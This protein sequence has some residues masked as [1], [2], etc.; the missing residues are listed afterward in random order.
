MNY[1]NSFDSFVIKNTVILE[2]K[3]VAGFLTAFLLSYAST[4][5]PKLPSYI[6]KLFNNVIMKTLAFFLIIY[7]HNRNPTVALISAI[8]FLAI[9]MILNKIQPAK[10]EKMTMLDL[11]TDLLENLNNL[12]Q[13]AMDFVTTQEGKIVLDETTKA[14]QEGVLHP[15]EAEMLIN[16]II[17]AEEQ[18]STPLVA[19]SDEGA[20][21]MSNIA[22]AVS[23]GKIP[24]DEGKRIAAQIVINENI[25][26]TSETPR[27][28]ISIFPDW[29]VNIL[30]MM[31]YQ[32][33]DQLDK[34]DGFNSYAPLH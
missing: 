3:Y 7:T 14:V 9:M 27:K 29:N 24:S 10:K 5:A 1:I 17:S 30:D 28:K 26:D 13:E 32:N 33:D 12:L 22:K 2:N 4:F 25:V 34:F 6:T 11:N 23:E 16:K 18:G 21:H 15:A 31:Q 20:Q 19:M 8:A